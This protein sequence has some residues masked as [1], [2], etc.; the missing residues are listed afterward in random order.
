M[1]E[2]ELNRMVSAEPVRGL[3]VLRA[4]VCRAHKLLHATATHSQVQFLEGMYLYNHTMTHFSLSRS[5]YGPAI[6]S[7]SRT[8]LI[9]LVPIFPGDRSLLSVLSRRSRELTALQSEFTPTTQKNAWR[10]GLY[11]EWSQTQLAISRILILKS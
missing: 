11:V 4:E 2:A 7:Y 5:Y 1:L 6:A 3:A 8:M 9:D 10:R